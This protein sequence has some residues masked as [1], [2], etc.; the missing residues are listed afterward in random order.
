[1]FELEWT[2]LYSVSTKPFV[3]PYVRA[4]VITLAIKLYPDFRPKGLIFKQLSGQIG[5]SPLCLYQWL[6]TAPKYFLNMT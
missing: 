2:E 6:L 3:P 4:Y 1:M 5:A